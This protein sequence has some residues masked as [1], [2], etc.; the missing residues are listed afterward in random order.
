MPRLVLWC[1]CVGGVWVALCSSAVASEQTKAEQ[2]FQVFCKNWIQTLNSYARNNIT[3]EQHGDLFVAE[4]TIS[5]DNMSTEVKQAGKSPACFVGTLR[6]REKTYQSC[7]QDRSRA[8]Q[9]PYLLA[10]ESNVT[11]IFLYKNGRWEY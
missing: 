1:C 3:C 6:Y 4:Y 2:T 9:G 7:S 10:R 8:L 11:Q 5:D